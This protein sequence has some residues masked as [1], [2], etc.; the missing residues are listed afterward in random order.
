MKK[1]ITVILAALLSSLLASSQNLNYE[2]YALKF[3]S[4]GHPTPISRWVLGG[5]ANDSVNIFFM[6][7]L[8]KGNNGKNILVDAGF[9]NDLEDAKDFDIIDYVRPDSVLSRIGLSSGEITDIILSHPHW[10]H[11]DGI[12]LF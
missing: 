12:D 6:T 9:L 4:L 10:D 8:I 2:V 3:A 7:W 1:T 11:I 5:P